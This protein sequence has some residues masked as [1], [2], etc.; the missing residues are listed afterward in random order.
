MC[1][2]EKLF[3]FCLLSVLLFHYTPAHAEG[4]IQTSYERDG[5]TITQYA[6]ENVDSD[7]CQNHP[8][9]TERPTEDAE[10][11]VGEAWCTN[12][13]ESQTPSCSAPDTLTI[14]FTGCD[15]RANADGT[16]AANFT[17]ICV[18]DCPPD[19]EAIER[20]VGDNFNAL[21]F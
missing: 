2:V 6:S 8:P 7:T 3:P 4:D 1:L 15:T 12:F 21:L 11:A 14:E 18:C 19:I 5:T 10:A 20:L 17:T 16:Y 9:F 13:C